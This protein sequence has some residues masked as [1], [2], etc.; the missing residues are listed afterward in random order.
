MPS[1]L[2]SGWAGR[3]EAV[4]PLLIVLVVFSPGCASGV[5]SPP[6]VVEPAEPA[7]LLSPRELSY[8]DLP[9]GKTSK[10]RFET[11]DAQIEI[12]GYATRFRAFSL[13]LAYAPFEIKV[14]TSTSFEVPHF[15][16]KYLFCPRIVLLDADFRIVHMSRFGDLEEK[17][18]IFGEPRFELTYAVGP[19]A[20]DARYLL[21]VREEAFDGRS[22]SSMYA[23]DSGQIDSQGRERREEIQSSRTGPARVS[24]KSLRE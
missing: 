14:V 9:L 22:V 24:L 19:S 8:E 3:H 12:D 16:V 2:P 17:Q 6:R 4:L 1:L 13:P 15:P 21:V 23:D 7:R 10:F 5:R 11:A 18:K 20:R